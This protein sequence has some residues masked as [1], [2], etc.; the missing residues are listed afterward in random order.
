MAVVIATFG[1]GAGRAL[2][3]SLGGSHSPGPWVGEW[4]VGDELVTVSQR[5]VLGPE[6]LSPVLCG[7]SYPPSRSAA[8]S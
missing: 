2:P 1:A 5:L 8:L 4:P 7:R 3:G 6:P